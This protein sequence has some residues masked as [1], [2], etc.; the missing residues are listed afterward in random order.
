MKL[1]NFGKEKNDP[2]DLQMKAIRNKKISELSAGEK[3]IKYGF[4]AGKNK[5]GEWKPDQETAEIVQHREVPTDFPN[6]HKRMHLALEFPALNVESIYYWFVKFYKEMQ[7]C[8]KLIKVT[9]NLSTSVAS[10][11]FGNIQSRISAQQNQASQYLKGI[12]EMVKGLFQ[13]VREIRVIDDRLTYYKDSEQENHELARSSEIVLKGFW[14]DQVEGGSK[15]PTSVYGMAQQ[16]GFT[17]LPD[18]FFSFKPTKKNKI[19]EEVN[20]LKF[21][22]KIKEILMRKL[23]QYYEWKERTGGELKQRRMFEIK[24]LRQHHD[25]IRL[26]ISWIKP[27]LRNIKRLQLHEKTMDTASIIHSFETNMVE[28]ETLYARGGFG[29]VSLNADK[30]SE[31]YGVILWHVNYRVKPEL[32][33]HSYEYQNKGPIHVGRADIVVRA[34]SWSEKQIQDYVDYRKAEEIELLGAI[35]ESIQA[36]LDTLGDELMKYLK[37]AGEKF[38]GDKSKEKPVVNS[39]GFMEPFIGVFGGL[40]DSFGA[41]MPG[42]KDKGPK[43]AKEKD[44]FKGEKVEKAAAKFAKAAVFEGIYRY[45]QAVGCT[46]W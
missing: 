29:K 39:Q 35:D 4:K 30:K 12:S 43:P 1:P 20:K 31:L 26:Y 24:Y 34:Y 21:N 32:A 7:G 36:A 45:K 38:P 16:V 14:I 23:R 10:S 33:F 11:M 19:E 3:L 15:N 2:A 6:S 44:T 5:K 46:Y 28:I 25:T 17:I 8:E 9:D 37:E 18:L 22:R 41:M 40:K 27:Y 42:K 13:I